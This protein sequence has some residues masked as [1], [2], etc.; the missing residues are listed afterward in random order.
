MHTNMNFPV[1]TRTTFFVRTLIA[2]LF[3]LAI[4]VSA[5]TR[6]DS[7]KQWTTPEYAESM[8]QSANTTLA[9]VYPWL[10]QWL[11]DEFHLADK[12]GTGIDLG[13]GPG[14]L[15][16]ELCSRTS[17]MHWINADINPHFFPVFLKDAQHAGFSDR[18]STQ[19]ADAQRL[20]FANNSADIIVSRGSFQ[21]WDNQQQAFA[22]IYRVL[23][24]GGVAFIGRGFSPNMP[25][26][27]ARQVR[28]KQMAGGGPPKYTVSKTYSQMQTWMRNLKITTY[29]IHRPQPA[30]SD[31][32][33][34][35]IWL[36]IRKPSQGATSNDLKLVSADTP[37]A[38][39]YAA[40]TVL[41]TERRWRNLVKKPTL[42]SP[43]LEPARTVISKSN[44]RKQGAKTIIEAL[45]YVP[46]GWVETRGRK[47]KQFFSIRG[48]K[49]PYPEYA[50]AGAWQ[51]EF[52]ELPYFFSASDIERIEVIR[53][54]AA[55]LTGLS[56]MTGIINIIPREYDRPE[57]SAELEYG[58]YQGYRAHLSHGAK[59]DNIS[60]ALSFG[61][62]HTGGPGG[63]NADENI[64]TA[65]GSFRWTPRDDVSVETNIFHLDGRRELTRAEPPAA[66]RFQ[67]ILSEFNPFRA[68]LVNGKIHRRYGEKASTELQWQFANRKHTFVGDMDDP[69]ITAKEDDHEW[70]VNI[71]QALS[72]SPNNMLRFGGL[73]NHWVAP[74]GKRFF[75]GRR[76]D[77]ETYSAVVADEHRLGPLVLDGGLR[78]AKTHL[79]EYGA[80]NINGSPK[81]LT[82]VEPIQD[83]WEPSIINTT[84]G[85]AW[86]A[87]SHV[88]LHV[89]AALGHLRPRTGSMD[90]NMKKPNNERRFKLDVGAIGVHPNI[91][92]LALTG[93]LVHQKDA[94]A[95][96][97]QTVTENNRILELYINRNQR[98]LGME[99]DARLHQ[100]SGVATPFVNIVVMS[101]NMENG[102]NMARNREIPRFITS[103]GLSLDKQV[104]DVNI[105][106]KYVSGYESARFAA[107]PT[108]VDIG[109]YFTLNATAG[110]SFGRQHSSRIYAEIHN[111]TDKHFSTVVGYPDFGRRFTGGVRFTF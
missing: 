66:S 108:P 40:D 99:L 63:S 65:R 53:S 4:N 90:V 2:L 44:I 107:T 83:V 105:F 104:F 89:N 39:E 94:I 11:T 1:Q 24:P 10:A 69:H 91:G 71:L 19:T 26:D 22:E 54:S 55:L 102:G 97:G 21:F 75:V 34:Y 18:V 30:E 12:T 73:Y 28:D 81:G 85:A 17:Q 41:V 80:F 46:G 78:W 42:E 92:R 57:T 50:I 67:N 93:F 13:S 38:R 35:G 86:H 27:I 106:W 23:A 49:Y 95:L 70:G 111:L 82:N 58:S 43:A 36:E 45:E 109:D 7:Q 88:S 3:L 47:V 32:V 98:Q 51:R 64:W 72:L 15:I 5:Q 77:M 33:L 96:S 100:I 59:R 56:G 14:T 110:W 48:Q 29:T 68:T 79:N 74:N 103:G 9:P 31:G 6:S 60:Y 101:S 52:H 16:F 20:P 37:G 76:T 87:N 62:A 61:P 84:L 8:F 25:V